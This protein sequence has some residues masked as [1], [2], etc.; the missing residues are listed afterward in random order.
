[1]SGSVLVMNVT[2]FSIIPKPLTLSLLGVGVL[3]LLGFI[4]G[5]CQAMRKRRD[6]HTRI[7]EEPKSGHSESDSD[8]VLLV[9]DSDSDILTTEMSPLH[10]CS[11]HSESPIL[12][13]STP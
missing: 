5:I 11:E 3:F 12:L 4:T 6:S 13:E 9:V 1:M 8:D 2:N 7:P 10:E